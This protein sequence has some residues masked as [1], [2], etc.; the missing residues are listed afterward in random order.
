MIV[1]QDVLEGSTVIIYIGSIVGI[2]LRIV[3]EVSREIENE[4]DS[5]G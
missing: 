3:W 4:G 5:K 2:M 1:L